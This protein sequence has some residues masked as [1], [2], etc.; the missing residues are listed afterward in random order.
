MKRLK[1]KSSMN[2]SG[3]QP[4]AIKELVSGIKKG[5]DHQTLLGVTGS[6][7]TYTM[8]NII[9]QTNKATLILAPNKTLAAQL[10]SEMKEFFLIIQL[11]ILFLI[12]IINR[13]HMSLSQIHLLKKMHL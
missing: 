5:T 7:K 4:V 9:D 2:P 1:I 11:S 6:G 10:Y 3:D 13:K 8:A 12:M